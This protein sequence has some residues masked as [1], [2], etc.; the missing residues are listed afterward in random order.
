M[1]AQKNRKRLR[2]PFRRR[3]P[4]VRACD[5]GDER[6][7]V[8]HPHDD[9]ASSSSRWTLRSLNLRYWR[10]ASKSMDERSERSED[11]DVV[12]TFEVNSEAA[13]PILSPM[14]GKYSPEFPFCTSNENECRLSERI[15]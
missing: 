15:A 1:K 4:G 10:H 11:A 8:S 7:T 2:L 14:D 12:V 3:L 5:E 6:S 13:E 9:S